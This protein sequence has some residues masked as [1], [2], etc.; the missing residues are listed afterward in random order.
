LNEKM[1]A[2]AV[3]AENRGDTIDIG[4]QVG[5]LGRRQQQATAS[6]E[7][8]AGGSAQFTSLPNEHAREVRPGV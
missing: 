3:I 8:I 6:T 4:S 1:A 2:E 7:A 5:R